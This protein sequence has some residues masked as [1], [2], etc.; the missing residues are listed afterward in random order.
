M[1]TS[2]IGFGQLE[3]ICG[4][5]ELRLVQRHTLLMHSHPIQRL[6]KLALFELSILLS[7]A[8]VLRMAGYCTSSDSAS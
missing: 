6:A 2:R 7:D 1:T 4:K 8:H 5:A 3:P